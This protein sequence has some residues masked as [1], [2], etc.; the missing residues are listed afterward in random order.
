MAATQVG[1]DELKQTFGHPGWNA[2][3]KYNKISANPR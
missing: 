2:G 3:V 1:M